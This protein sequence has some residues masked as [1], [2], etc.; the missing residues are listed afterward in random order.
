MTI[1]KARNIKSGIIAL[2][3][4]LGVLMAGCKTFFPSVPVTPV[5]RPDGVVVIAAKD[6]F[7]YYT[8]DVKSAD[9]M[10]KG[11]TLQVTGYLTMNRDFMG[12][13]IIVLSP[14]KGSM[15]NVAVQCYLRD[16][17]DPRL[18]TLKI[19]NEVTVLG[20]C[21]GLEMDIILKNGSL[22]DAPEKES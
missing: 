12:T 15:W 3:L 9:T 2:L 13:R 10:F 17:S 19:G 5:V 6:L 1:I 21:Q 16:A 8:A 4:A 11:K 7:S 20:E 14:G 18:Q 22:V